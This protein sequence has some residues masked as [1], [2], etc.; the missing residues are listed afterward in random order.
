MSESSQSLVP[1]FDIR[2]RDADIEA[3]A[4]TL[5]SGWLTMGPRTAIRGRVRRPPGRSSRR[6]HVELHHGAPPRIP[7]GG[8]RPRGRGD[9]PR[10]HLRRQRRRGALLRRRP[11]PRRLPRSSRLR[12]PRRCRSELGPNEVVSVVHMSDTPATSTRLRELCDHRG[13][14]LIED[15]ATRSALAATA[16]AG[17]AVRDGRLLQPLLEQAAV[18]RRGWL[19]HHRRRRGRGRCARSAPTR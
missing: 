3:V 13:M 4:E 2:L 19:P 6:R 11:R 9:R 12:R 10:D 5:R 16:T 15:A 14:V 8:G 17:W 7:R 1:L 18:R